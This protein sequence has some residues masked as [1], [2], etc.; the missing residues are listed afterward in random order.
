MIWNRYMRAAHRGLAVRQFP[1][2]PGVSSAVVPDVRGK[3]IEEATTALEKAGFSVRPQAVVSWQ[4]AGTV[5]AQSP[6]PG[7]TVSAGAMITVSVSDGTG[8]SPRPSPPPPSPRPSHTPSASPSPSAKPSASPS[9]AGS[10]SPVPSPSGS[11][12]PD[13][14]GD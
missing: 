3:P 8:P 7:E 11:A 9:P 14:D 12:T 10:G 13:E 5:I 1:A 4:P 2:P 6:P